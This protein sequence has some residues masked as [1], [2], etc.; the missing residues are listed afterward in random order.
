MQPTLERTPVTQARPAGEAAFCPLDAGPWPVPD[1]G[2]W[3]A[4]M[5]R[6]IVRG[7]ISAEAAMLTC[8]ERI[9]L[10]EP[11]VRAFAH[12]DAEKALADARERDRR[13]ERGTLHGV[14]IGLKD[15]I[16]TADYPTEYGSAIYEGHRPNRDAEIVTRVTR[17]G[18]V[19]AGKTVCTEFCAAPPGPTRN[20]RNPAH[21]PGGSSSGSAAAVACGMVPLAVGTQTAGSIVRPASFCGVVGYKPTF[22]VLPRKG[23]KPTSYSLDTIGLFGPDVESVAYLAGTISGQGLVPPERPPAPRI[24]VCVTPHWAKADPATHALIAREVARLAA[25]GASVRPLD[26]PPHFDEIDEVQRTIWDFELASCLAEEYKNHRH[27]MRDPLP[28]H[29]E[30]GLA[31]DPERFFDALRFTARCR[32]LMAEL[33][34]GVDVLIA[35]STVGEA[36]RGLESTGDPIFNMLWTL[37]RMPCVH[38]PTATGPRG[39]PMGFQV[40]GREHEDAAAFAAARW[41]ELHLP[42]MPL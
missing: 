31:R 9:E 39:M 27:R 26:L 22:G 4:D 32:R 8:I 23:L 11:V 17:Q 20:P 6:R 28:A 2:P 14:P 41:V 13:S 24:G 33:T 34:L 35:P 29:I 18:A 10:L 40:V 7:E 3:N 36:P 5:L 21:T 25:A 16:D 1:R 38:V 12:F 42:V 30:R 19:I 15:A 37:F